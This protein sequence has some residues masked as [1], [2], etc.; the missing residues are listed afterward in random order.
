[1]LARK[2]TICVLINSKTL[3]LPNSILT[4]L[5]GLV[6]T[7]NNVNATL[8]QTS[9]MICAADSQVQSMVDKFVQIAAVYVAQF[10]QMQ[11]GNISMPCQVA[12]INGIQKLGCQALC[13]FNKCSSLDMDL[14]AVDTFVVNAINQWSNFVNTIQSCSTN[15]KPSTCLTTILVSISSFYGICVNFIL[16]QPYQ[17]H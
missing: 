3:P 8:N 15:A 9:A 16:A 4:L 11:K 2:S 7:L 13:D 5:K 14:S 10:F 1:M 12:L 17:L 6:P